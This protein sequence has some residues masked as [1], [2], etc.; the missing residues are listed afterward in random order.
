MGLY[1]KLVLPRLCDLAMRNR[2]FWPYRRAAVAAAEGRVLE[3]GAGAGLNL[4]LYPVA[5]REIFALEPDPHLRSLA[6]LRAGNLDR[7]ISLLDAMA[8]AIPLETA[9]VD[10]VVTTWTL[11][12]LPDLAAALGE[13]RRVL[14]PGGR[15]IFVEHGLAPDAAVRKWQDRLT[16][17][18]KR[19]FG[20]CHL[21]RPIDAVIEAGGFAIETLSCAYAPAPR[22]VGYLYQG[23]A[24]A[25]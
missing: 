18:W 15:L 14:K 25:T 3:I 12:T 23:T 1:R 2:V 7:P 4:A 6:E 5:V 16:P 11:C 10:A 24:R 9:S 19:V 17:A 21:N 8:E 22:I 20:G 13:A